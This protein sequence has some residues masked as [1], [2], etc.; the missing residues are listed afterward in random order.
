[1]SNEERRA[2]NKKGVWVTKEGR[3]TPVGKM[4]T[5]HLLNIWNIFN[6]KAEWFSTTIYAFPTPQGDMAQLAYE[7]ECEYEDIYGISTKQELLESFAF[8]PFLVK[9][10]KKRGV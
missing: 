4:Q 10:L 9:E 6:K 5:S 7:A 8:Y 1:M 2:W 3:K